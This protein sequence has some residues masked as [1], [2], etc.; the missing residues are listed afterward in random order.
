M[1]ETIP[2]EILNSLTKLFEVGHTPRPQFKCTNLRM[3]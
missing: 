3:G 2:L 1:H